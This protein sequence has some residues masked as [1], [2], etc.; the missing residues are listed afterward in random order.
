MAWADLAIAAAGT[1]AWELAF[2]GLPAVVLTL[3][4]NQIEVAASL[5]EAGICDSLTAQGEIA[6]QT[7]TD[8]VTSLMLDQPR[9]ERMSRLGRH[10]VDGLGCER[11]LARIRA[12]DIHLHA[13]RDE[14]SH[15]VWGWA[16]D[17]ETRAM[18]FNSKSIAWEDHLQWYRS[19]LENPRCFFY[20]A[21]DEQGLPI[22]QIR[23][24]LDGPRA[25][26]SVGLAFEAR[27]RS[28]GSPV[29]IRALDELY[30]K[31]DVTAVHAYVKPINQAS[32]RT[33]LKA[34]FDEL[35]MTQVQG[36][37]AKHFVYSRKTQ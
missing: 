18:S 30:T 32:I 11:V 5:N 13:A 1:T 17:S 22:G 12:A 4:D 29:V 25:V 27:G 19:K 9:R 2:M 3:A 33:F 37:E 35:E 31:A 6:T 16:N 21:T 24:D 10:L 14:D 34:D 28:L 36:G 23:F 8:N 15:T 26:I 20:I 7:I